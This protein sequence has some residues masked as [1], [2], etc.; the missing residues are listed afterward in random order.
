[1]FVSGMN[2]SRDSVRSTRPDLAECPVEQAALVLGSELAQQHGR[3]D[4]PRLD[5]RDGLPSFQHGLLHHP[6]FRDISFGSA[7]FSSAV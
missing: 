5:R 6:D 3:R 2:C 1:M 7:L 4:P